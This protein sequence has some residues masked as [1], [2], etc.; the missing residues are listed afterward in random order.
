MYVNY[1]ICI[2]YM[3]IYKIK[4]EI[5]LDKQKECYRKL[6]T[7]NKIPDDA[8]LNQYIITKNRS[9]LSIFD[10]TDC[11]TERNHCIYC[12]KD[13]D[14]LLTTDEDLDRL[15]EILAANNYSIN[16]QLT[17]LIQKKDKNVMFYIYKN[18]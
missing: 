18:E 17:E 15:L 3:S 16:Y 8:G 12:F 11:C 5:Y 9:K 4:N 10:Y 14:K 13:N 2:C 1:C 6:L 7:I